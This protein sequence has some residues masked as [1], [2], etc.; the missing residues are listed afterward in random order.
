MAHMCEKVWFTCTMTVELHKQG[1]ESRVRNGHG[2]AV[3]WDIKEKE[4]PQ[5]LKIQKKVLEEL[6]GKKRKG[7]KQSLTNKC[8]KCFETLHWFFGKK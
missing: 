1:L 6:G 2:G 7:I 5:V 8:R 4:R 3:K